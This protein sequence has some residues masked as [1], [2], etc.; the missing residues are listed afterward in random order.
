M[1]VT[2]RGLVVL[3]G[4]QHTSAC[5]NVQRSLTQAPEHVRIDIA[6]RVSLTSS[7]MPGLCSGSSI[8]ARFCSDRMPSTRSITVVPG[9][10]RRY[11]SRF[12]SQSVCRDMCSKAASSVDG[13]GDPGAAEPA[14][15]A[16]TCK[17][18]HSP[19]PYP[20]RHSPPPPPHAAP[21]PLALCDA[22]LLGL[23]LCT[24]ASKVPCSNSGRV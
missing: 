7:E 16:K 17:R 11:S 9:W 18:A 21:S 22:P 8:V 5:H 1:G 3:W 23:S 14:F 13:G 19:P 24:M 2:C 10:R 20:A 12:R 6:S 15:S 4:V